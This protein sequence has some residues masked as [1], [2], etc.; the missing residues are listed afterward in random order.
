MATTLGTRLYQIVDPSYRNT[1]LR[2]GLSRIDSPADLKAFLDQNPAAKA[3]V[4]A[5]L[6]NIQTTLKDE[7]QTLASVLQGGQGVR[8]SSLVVVD[9]QLRPV[10]SVTSNVIRIPVDLDVQVEDLYLELTS[11]Q[12][13]RFNPLKAIKRWFIRKQDELNTALGK[14]Q[15]LLG[16]LMK[17]VDVL[18]Q[19]QGDPA[20]VMQH[21][22]DYFPKDDPRLPRFMR[23]GLSLAKKFDS[24][25]WMKLATYAI[26]L[27]VNQMARRFI[28]GETALKARPRLHELAG[29]GVGTIADILGEAVKSEEEARAYVETY[30]QLVEDLA[31]DTK[32]IKQVRKNWAE[33]ESRAIVPLFKKEHRYD[34]QVSIKLSSFYSQWNTSDPI[35]TAFVVKKRLRELLRKIQTTERK[36]DVQI[37]LTIDLEQYQYRDLTYRIFKEIMDEKEFQGMERVGVVVQT[38]LKDAPQII[39]DL[40][41][42]SKARQDAG[43][44]RSI[45]IRPVKG[46]YVDYE[47][48]QNE[49]K[50][51]PLATVGSKEEADINYHDCV[52]LLYAYKDYLRTSIASHND[53]TYLESIAKAIENDVP[54]EVQMLLGMQ[55][56]RKAQL[57]ELGV[58]VSAYVPI[59]YLLPGMA[60]LARR[61]LENASQSNFLFKVASNL[62]NIAKILMNPKK[63][64]IDLVT[65]ARQQLDEILHNPRI[66]PRALMD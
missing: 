14:N 26:K 49:Q 57:F 38:Y 29:N 25:K 21:L 27:A 23:W 3:L 65:L 1:A 45:Q 4:A 41:A 52:D 46:A 50:G 34:F 33:L 35:G 5:N 28:A 43:F 30:K 37:G 20:E 51:Y 59:G 62:S 58:P 40:A 48:M 24:E 61:F 11:F 10:S 53:Q 2:S 66:Q 32:L 54:I 55:D 47:K 64:A 22:K 12:P 15:D 16:D 36:K 56:D 39:H 17:F 44:G 42:W 18:P 19:I 60:Y 13:G 8:A 31:S 9:P 6:A 7:W 63:Y